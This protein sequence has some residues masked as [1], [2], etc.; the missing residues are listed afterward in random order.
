[1]YPGNPGVPLSQLVANSL[2]NSA[3]HVNNIYTQAE[4]TWANMAQ[5]SPPVGAV[6]S[7]D[8]NY[9]YNARLQ[10]V[11]NAHPEIIHQIKGTS[12]SRG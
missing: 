7:Q 4:Q 10:E 11:M 2:G 9:D 3:A 6:V 1:M 5:G 12:G 8:V